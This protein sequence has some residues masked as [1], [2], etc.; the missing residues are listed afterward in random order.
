VIRAG[1]LCRIAW[2]GICF[3]LIAILLTGGLWP[4]ITY[5]QVNG[6]DVQDVFID[7][8]VDVT[9]PDTVYFVSARTGLSSTYPINGMAET[10]FGGGVL[11]RDRTTRQPMLLKA[12]G[13]STPIGFMAAPPIQIPGW[14]VSTAGTWIAWV[15][16]KIEAKS[17]L[18]DLIVAR[19]D[20]SQKRIA[21]H[22][23]SATGISIT[24]IAVSRDGSVIVYSRQ[25]IASTP[26]LYPNAADVSVWRA[27]TAA[28]VHLPGEP[29]CACGAAASTD[30][31]TVFRLDKRFTVHLIDQASGADLQIAPPTGLIAA[32]AGDALV[33]PGGS[34]AVYSFATTADARL[35]RYGL[36]V[37]DAARQVQTV[38]IPPGS[39]RYQP[40]AFAQDSL[41][42]S[43]V[44]QNGTYRVPLSGGTPTAIAA[45]SYLG[46]LGG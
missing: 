24:P 5:G 29:L 22:T 31:K 42:L 27:Q 3:A 32:V 43:A 46:T 10:V 35:A 45:D 17:L 14:A 12:D 15:E 7:H 34:L 37:V 36:I 9:K 26:L 18:S 16:T 2:R 30:G 6:G 4:K 33:Q 41:L 1:R 13:S 25:A 38:L 20:G 11:Y 44:N 39:V 21:V 8:P 28:I 23:S 40:I 19:A